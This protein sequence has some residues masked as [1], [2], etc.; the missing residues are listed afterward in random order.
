VQQRGWSIGD[1]RETTMRI[2]INMGVPPKEGHICN[3]S[4]LINNFRKKNAK[5][6]LN[7]S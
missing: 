2:T 3:C 4:H 5:Y 7:S 6:N 1:I